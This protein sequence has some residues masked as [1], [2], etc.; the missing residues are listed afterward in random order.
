MSQQAT[1]S[2]GAAAIEGRERGDAIGARRW[3]IFAVLGIAAGG[4]FGDLFARKPIAFHHPY[5][6]AA[7]ETRTSE[8]E[9]A[10]EH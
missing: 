4:R 10:H 9:Q 3:W 8:E 6:Y 7:N 1:E 2:R 5:A